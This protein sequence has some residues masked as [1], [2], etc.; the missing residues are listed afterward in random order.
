MLKRKMSTIKAVIVICSLSL[1]AILGFAWYQ[2]N[3]NRVN[4][5]LWHTGTGAAVVDEGMMLLQNAAEQFESKT[6]TKVRFID[7]AA[8]SQEDFFSKRRE[9]FLSGDL[10]DMIL[11]NTANYDELPKIN[12]LTSQLLPIADVLENHEDVLKGMQG[13]YFSS[14]SGLIS[15][16]ILNNQLVGELGEDASKC[17]WRADEVAALFSTWGQNRSEEMN[18]LDFRIFASLEMERILSVTDGAY[19]LDNTEFMRSVN[20]LTEFAEGFPV[21]QMDA[22]DAIQLYVKGQGGRYDA[23]AMAYLSGAA[24]RPIS[25]KKQASFNAFDL[26][27]LAR[28][29]NPTASGAI[30][31]AGTLG[32][33]YGFALVD[34][35]AEGRARAIDFANFLTS[36][37]FQTQLTLNQTSKNNVCG[38]VLRSVNQRMIA[39][40]QQGILKVDG[41][42][43]SQA[44]ITGFEDLIKDLDEPGKLFMR[45]QSETSNKV[46]ETMM[47]L[48]VSKLLGEDLSEAEVLEVVEVLKSDLAKP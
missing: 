10:P 25:F 27:E 21:R 18:A 12:E 39:D 5:L 41:E 46:L 36:E 44:A 23:D 38:S 32:A 3:E 35:D 9:L 33:F 29:V 40:A 48:S 6:G 34:Q 26:A 22:S 1:I 8:D 47:T 30:I 45:C 24:S 11:F 28:R 37:D 13:T 15:G 14:I 42:Q 7:L 43:I 31:D 2:Q 4:V 16:V 19:D 17:Y 20:A